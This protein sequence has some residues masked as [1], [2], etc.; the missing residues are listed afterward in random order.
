MAPANPSALLAVQSRPVADRPEPRGSDAP[1]GQFAGLMAQL[2]PKA[3]PRQVHEPVSNRPARTGKAR[4]GGPSETQAAAAPPAPLA[5]PAP[6]KGKPE[7][8]TSKADTTSHSQA[9][10]A[11]QTDDSGSQAE[12]ASP[13]TAEPNSKVA[14]PA[15]KA[16]EPQPAAP[17]TVSLLPV[18]ALSGSLPALPASA[19]QSVPNLGEASGKA[20][21]DDAS[22]PGPAPG[23][24]PPTPMAVA[25]KIQ[26]LLAQSPA[27]PT[28]A[29]A[30]PA[31]P[32]PTMPLKMDPKAAAFTVV[33]DPGLSLAKT[34]VPATAPAPQP[35]APPQLPTTNQAEPSSEPSPAP[36]LVLTQAVLAEPAPRTKEGAKAEAPG[37]ATDT[38]S[39]GA[40]PSGKAM[41]V[42]EG[43]V[44][45]QEPAPMPAQGLLAA[46][47]PTSGQPDVSELIRP[48]AQ[49]SL[50]PEQGL[51][52]LDAPVAKLLPASES[53]VPRAADG[54]ALA[55][56][57]PL[58]RL[59]EPTSTA[60]PAAPPASATPRSTPVLQVEG[61]LRWMLKGGVQEAQLQL[62]PD[63]LGQVTIHLRVEGGEVHAR[64]WVTE[65][66]SVQ[67]VQ[68]GR[69]QLE[70]SL[71]EQGLM[72]GSFD[73]QQGQ[74]PFQEAH[75]G[76]S[77]HEPV[78][79]ETT[80]ARQEAPAA[81]PLSILNPRH[82]ELYA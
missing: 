57:G 44:P 3:A 42:V 16:D 34:A 70:L 82:V 23:A 43:W 46:I 27:S 19:I 78:V 56:L 22:R 24:L 49:A 48:G 38:P 72:L 32:A 31:D 35:S 61:G 40:A 11:P 64:L 4:P 62:H 66:A 2:A 71:K 12:A 81:A 21:P 73:L 65:P 28:L 50:I 76:P 51:S 15:P 63:S 74:R 75:A 69:P 39:A 58:S 18:P 14:I 9:A 79:P 54:P 45:V 20:S 36:T 67:A 1:E 60:T 8:P 59:L 68:E 5:T 25:A 17:A 80:P 33:P 55:A 53:P 6:S 52:L 30:G 7:E 13:T 41:K 37:P 29:P 77:F 10:P 26:P 47:P